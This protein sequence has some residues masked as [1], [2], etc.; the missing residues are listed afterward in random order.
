MSITFKFFL[1]KTSRR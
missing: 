1:I